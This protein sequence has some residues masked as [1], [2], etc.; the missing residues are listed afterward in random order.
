MLDKSYRESAKVESKDMTPKIRFSFWR[1]PTILAY[2]FLSMGA[3]L[4]ALA[5]SKDYALLLSIFW[6]GIVFSIV[7]LSL[8][9]SAC[10]FGGFTLWKYHF[11]WF[12][13]PL[14]SHYLFISLGFEDLE[15][16]KYFCSKV[17]RKW[18]I[19]E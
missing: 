2:H 3:V 11:L 8:I 1:V 7:P 12:S 16:W 6:I 17:D 5:D 18:D 15:T 4:S 9:V 10:F 13:L 19:G 14:I